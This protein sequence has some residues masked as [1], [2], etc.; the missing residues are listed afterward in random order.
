[1]TLVGA[2][3]GKQIRTGGHVRYLELMESLARR[4]NRVVVL[5]NGLLPYEGGSFQRIAHSVPYRRK[6]FPPASWIFR[7]EAGR[8]AEELRAAAGRPDAVIVFGE[9]HLA[10]G[11]R[12]ARAL[13]APLVYGHRSNTVREALT[14]LEE[15]GHSRFER[16]RI[17]AELWKSR[18]DERRIARLG[19]LLV[20]QS[21]YDRDDFLARNPGASGRCAVIRGDISGPRFKPEYALANASERVGKICFMGTQGPRKGID[22]LVD[23]IVEL[24]R[25]G[26]GELRFRLCGPGERREE[27]EARLA[28]GGASEMAVVLGRVPNPFEEIVAADLL[29]VPSLFDSYP[30]TVLEAL[31]AGT[32]VIG[33]RVGGIPDM[34][35][36]EELLFPPMDALAIADRIERCVREPAFY[37]RLREL[38]AARRAA[39][40]FDW[41]EAWEAAIQAGLRGRDA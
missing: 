25:R 20:F 31:H 35:E 26:L 34:L 16:L 2:F 5:M 23:A 10:A 41:A 12:L 30:N 11:S 19:E 24:K 21:A 38:C 36:S 7:A 4:G 1:M 39:F 14:Y 8:R 13:G 28:S 29:V 18:F 40:A 9:T 33:S 27:L 22:Y 3:L 6:S 15:A 37:A 32:P 17:R